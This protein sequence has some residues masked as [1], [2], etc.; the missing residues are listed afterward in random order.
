M[1]PIVLA[2][3]SAYRK[4]LLERLKLPF[5]T[6]APHIDET[7]L[8]N[9][10]PKAL[11][12]RLS[13]E[14]ANAVAAYY[15]QAVII[16]SDQVAILDGCILG[17]PGN[18]EAAKGQLKHSSGKTVTFLT[19]LTVLNN[20][21]HTAET[22]VD[23]YEVTFRPL[24]EQEIEHYLLKDKPYDCAGSFKSEG[25]GITLFEEMRGKD[26]TSLIGLPLIS[27]TTLLNKLGINVV[28]HTH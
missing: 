26:P 2:S 6:H 18:H 3:T 23:R 12:E 17:K 13:Y 20:I 1:Q 8:P 5:I 4:A 9:E 15:P 14:K 22:I 11:V 21:T 27:L 19:G 7:P 28:N 16:G 24:S 25:L 10:L